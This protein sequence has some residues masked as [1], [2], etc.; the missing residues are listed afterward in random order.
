MQNLTNNIMTLNDILKEDGWTDEEI[1]DYKDQM[2]HEQ[3]AIKD[4]LT[5]E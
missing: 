5:V 3:E 4:T 1:R 2:K